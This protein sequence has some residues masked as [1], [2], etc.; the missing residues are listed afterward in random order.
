MHLSLPAIF[1]V[2]FDNHNFSIILN[3]F[4]NNDPYAENTNKWK[5]WEQNTVYLVKDSDLGVKKLKKI[6]LENCSKSTTKRP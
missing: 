2:I 6:C 4:D 5:M 3:L 1:N